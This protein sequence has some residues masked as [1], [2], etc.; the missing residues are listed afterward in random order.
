[1]FWYE[2]Q[3][4]PTYSFQSIS[5]FLFASSF[6]PFSVAQV[7]S[8]V[9]VWEM[10][11]TLKRGIRK[12]EFHDSLL[13]LTAA[14]SAYGAFVGPL[15]PLPSIVGQ[16]LPSIGLWE[17][18]WVHSSRLTKSKGPQESASLWNKQA[19]SFTWQLIENC[20]FEWLFYLFIFF[21]LSG[22]CA[23]NMFVHWQ[24]LDANCFLQRILCTELQLITVFS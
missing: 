22:Y 1:M 17:K 10:G 12:C 9:G 5:L 14:R 15:A 6:Y 21:K 8:K 11:G 23:W 16:T 24:L 20:S 3:V 7:F 4:F 2:I 18:L 13:L 19:V